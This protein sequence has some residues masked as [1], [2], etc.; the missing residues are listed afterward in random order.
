MHYYELATL[1]I[2]MGKAADVAAGIE[3][4]V[5][6]ALTGRLLGVWFS[7]IGALNQVLV[8]REFK[9]LE[10]LQ[11]E[12][13]R[14]AQAPNPFYAQEWLEHV[15][16]DSY[17]GFPFLPEVETGAF[18]PAYEIRTYHMKHGGLPHVHA[19]WEAALPAR[20]ALSKL[21]VVMSSLDGEP[22]IV[23]IWPY[24]SVNQRSQV[25]AD[26]VAQGIWPPKGG[27]QWLTNDME[28]LIAMPTKASPLQ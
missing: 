24:E 12:R 21:T 5:A 26:A 8:L 23:N 22:R 9:S 27:P 25:R 19:A 2:H 4:F 17:Q 14:F 20:T 3:K 6:E 15:S 18:G 16:V 13:A 11:Q 1:D 28:S 10:D 7:D